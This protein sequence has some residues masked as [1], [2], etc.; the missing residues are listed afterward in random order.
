MKKKIVAVFATAAVAA[1][2]VAAT[3]GSQTEA[4]A[5]PEKPKA[6][7]KSAVASVTPSLCF[8]E[9]EDGTG[10][11]VDRSICSGGCFHGDG[12]E[13]RVRPWYELNE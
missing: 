7:D 1:S 10:F 2:A 9:Q 13:S 5:A 11:C 8:A 4:Q 3:C 6:D 12:T